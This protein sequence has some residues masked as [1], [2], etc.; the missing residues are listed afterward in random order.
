MASTV[1]G[2]LALTIFTAILGMFQFGFNTGVVN[3]PQTVIE[4]FI[5]DVYKARNEVV[6]EKS[7]TSTIFSLAVSAFLVGGMIGG[8]TGGPLANKVGR[9]QGIFYTQ[10]LSIIGAILSGISKPAST[11]EVL[12]I[13]RFLIGI[14]CGLFT[15]LVPLYITEVAPVNIRGGLGTFNQLAVTSG[16]FLSQILGLNSVLG[17]TD[18]WPILVSLTAIPAAIQAILLLFLPESPRFL[19]LDK[20]DEDAGKKALKKLRQTDDIDEEMEEI[21]AEANAS[22]DSGSLS[23]LQLLMSSELRLALFVTICMHLS[24]QLSGITAIFYYSTKFFQSAGIS[25]GNSQY[26]T[27]GV[28]AIMVTMTIV[29]I[30]LMDKLGRRTLHFVGI[31]GMIVCSILITIAL[32][33]SSLDSVD[34]LSPESGKAANAETD[35]AGVFAIVATLAF[36]VFF[37][38]GPG[39]IPWLIT[40]ELFTQAP[41]SAAIAI[42]TFVNWTGNLAVGLIF[43]QMQESI[44][45]FSFLPFTIILVILFAILYFYLPETRGIPVNEIEALFQTPNAW[46]TAIGRSNEM[47]LQ[48]IRAKN[49]TSYGATEDTVKA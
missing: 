48:E 32:N 34:C 19:I 11:Y 49:N 4:E 25:C 23:V 9:K 10:F 33:V 46:K 37:A 38:F 12:I 15:G 5:G 1:P 6:I 36:V 35:G 29:T 31:I 41:R 2:F 30:P 16:I 26:A 28:G 17:S 20:K 45:D 13:G 40:G 27:M 42:A 44:T 39:S 21:K 8:L 3:V 22:N 43:P 14:A 18:T 24:Q 47:L 7:L